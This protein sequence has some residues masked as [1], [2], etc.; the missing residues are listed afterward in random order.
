MLSARARLSEVGA[1]FDVGRSFDEPRRLRI[2][3]LGLCHCACV[4][5]YQTWCK[6]F[7]EPCSVRSVRALRRMFVLRV[8]GQRQTAH[9]G[10]WTD[11]LMRTKRALR[12]SSR[13]A[14]SFLQVWKQGAGPGICCLALCCCEVAQPRV[15]GKPRWVLQSRSRALSLSCLSSGIAL[16]SRLRSRSA[17]LSSTSGSGPTFLAGHCLANPPVRAALR[18][19]GRA[20]CRGRVVC[21]A[22]LAL[23][24]SAKIAVQ[25]RVHDGLHIPA[26]RRLQIDR[27]RWRGPSSA[28]DGAAS[29]PST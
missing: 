16:Q 18:V 23:Q 27:G 2:A 29:W 10:D 14:P 13:R 7:A 8:P 17:R 9:A 25:A 28:I 3:C 19:V 11:L 5:L 15:E 24:E 6:Y 1:A 26:V 20:R 21:S 4:C 12:L 22:Q